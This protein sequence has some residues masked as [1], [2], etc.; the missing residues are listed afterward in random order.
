MLPFKMKFNSHFSFVLKQ[1]KG[2]R[3][4]SRNCTRCRQCGSRP[5]HRSVPRPGA[6]R[7]PDEACMW[8][9]H[10]LGAVMERERLGG[11]FLISSPA[12]YVMNKR[13]MDIRFR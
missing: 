13:F 4:C 3:E 7:S 1:D 9:E 11:G 5:V 10:R 8:A 12:R 2:S 6:K